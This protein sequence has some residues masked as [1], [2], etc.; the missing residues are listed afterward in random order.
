MKNG[1]KIIAV[2]IKKFDVEIGR[3][4]FEIN[5][6]NKQPSPLQGRIIK[7]L[8]KHEGEAI[9][10][11]DLEEHCEV[12]KATMSQTLDALEY[13]KMIVRKADKNDAR[14]KRIVLTKKSKDKAKE[15]NKLFVS[16]DK[17]I[18]EGL[19]EREISAFL[20]TIEKMKANLSKTPSKRKNGGK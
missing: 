7:Y 8:S 18:T 5:K 17:K 6:D 4:L 9:Y 11:K 10:Q 14:R 13:E 1:E 19:T 2:E 3:Y 15:I 16:V 20:N 12:S